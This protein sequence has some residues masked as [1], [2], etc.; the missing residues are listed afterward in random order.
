MPGL[1][2]EPA[3]KTK[4]SKR[5]WTPHLYCSEAGRDARRASAVRDERKRAITW[6]ASRTLCGAEPPQTSSQLAFCARCQPSRICN[7]S[8]VAD[9]RIKNGAND[10]ESTLR[11]PLTDL[12]VKAPVEW[13]S[14][15]SCPRCATR[16]A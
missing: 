14:P 11:E 10:G 3:V 2:R 12:S 9:R 1:F 4:P 13:G 5:R 7:G 15:A 8:G 6:E 16:S